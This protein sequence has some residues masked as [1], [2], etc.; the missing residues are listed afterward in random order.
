MRQQKHGTPV[1]TLSLGIIVGCIVFLVG[2]YSSFLR[3]AT[4][5]PV[6]VL[7][8]LGHD[9]RSARQQSQRSQRMAKQKHIVSLWETLEES[10]RWLDEVPPLTPGVT[11]VPLKRNV[12]LAECSNDAFPV[13]RRMHLIMTHPCFRIVAAWPG[14][15][16]Y[17]QT[18]MNALPTHAC[19][20]AQIAL[21]PNLSAP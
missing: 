13:T 10:N 18:W 14:P 16:E 9:V 8:G 11:G 20:Q 19:V 7:S 5:E 1:Q 15:S 4:E 12:Q 2:R 3:Y 6:L 21:A 17:T